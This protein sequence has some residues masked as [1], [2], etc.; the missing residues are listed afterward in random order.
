MK[1]G[2]TETMRQL[3]FDF[4]KVIPRTQ[5][6]GCGGQ[7]GGGVSY[8]IADDGN[9]CPRCETPLHRERACSVCRTCGYKSCGAE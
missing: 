4:E 5:N 3:E 9:N 8:A 7:H 6:C 1:R 2:K